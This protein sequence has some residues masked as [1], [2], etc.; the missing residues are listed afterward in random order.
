MCAPPPTPGPIIAIF[1]G[2][3]PSLGPADHSSVR[4]LWDRPSRWEKGDIEKHMIVDLAQAMSY[5]ELVY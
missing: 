3:F 5:A 2:L 4:S 1:K